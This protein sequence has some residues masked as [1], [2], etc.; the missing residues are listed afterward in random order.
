MYEHTR[1]TTSTSGDRGGV[2]ASLP[3]PCPR[4]GAVHRRLAQG[5][6]LTCVI[7]GG[8][9][10]Q[11]VPPLEPTSPQPPVAPV[12]PAPPQPPVT[13]AE[14]IAPTPPVRPIPATPPATPVTPVTPAQPATP[15][16]GMRE[17]FPGLRIDVAQKLIEID[18]TVPIDAHN[19]RTPRVY[20]ELFVCPPDTKEHEAVA[21]TKVPPSQVHA[22]LLLLGLEPGSPGK[23][24]FEGKRLV[25]TPPKG[26]SVRV[27][28]AHEHNGSE[29]ELPATDWAITTRD[30]RTL[31]EFA[32]SERFVFA[33]SMFVKR[34]GR[35][36]YYADM[37]GTLIG[38]TTFGG[39]CIAWTGMHNPDSGIEEPHWIANSAAVPPFGTPIKVRIRPD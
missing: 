19:P 17:L 35:E 16:S 15:S 37:D 21:L 4:S 20:L 5:L 28:I 33:G 12:E 2:E 6:M 39:E 25:S 29:V 3:R 26:P 11:R 34:D 1:P 27:T 22:A 32:P 7:A 9:A 13:P 18:A 30:G 24:A 36:F 31:T 10:Q 38:L 23:F 8:C 14:P